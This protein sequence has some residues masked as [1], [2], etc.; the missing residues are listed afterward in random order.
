MVIVENNMDLVGHG[1]RDI[2]KGY[3]ESHDA[4]YIRTGAKRAE[5]PLVKGFEE[6]Y[7]RVCEN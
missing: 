5:N 1:Q 7:K 3:V 4:L 6:I 2:F